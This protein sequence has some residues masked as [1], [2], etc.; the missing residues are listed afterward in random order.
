MGIISRAVR[1][2]ERRELTKISPALL[3]RLDGR[4]GMWWEGIGAVST[5][6]A[7]RHVAVWASINYIAELIA[8]LPVHT[9][10][11]QGPARQMVPSPPLV[12]NP[13]QNVS[14]IAWRRQ[15]LV[16]AL[17]HGNAVGIITRR[18]PDTFQAREIEIAHPNGVG[19]EVK[20]RRLVVSYL[21][22]PIPRDDLFHLTAYETPGSPVGLSPIRYIATTVYAG[23]AAQEFGA[24]WFAEGATPAALLINDA[25][26]DQATAQTAKERWAGDGTSGRTPRV[27]GNGWRYQPVQVPADES[28]FLATINANA[29]HIATFYGL[30]P[31]DIGFKSGDSMTYQ[32]VEQAQI[33][34]LVY[35]VHAWVRRIEESL[36]AQLVAP[37]EY[38]K[39]NTD[40]LIRVD[41]ATRYRAHDSAI[42]MGLATVNERRA[43]EDMP[44]V[45]GGDDR[46]WPPYRAF[47]TADE[48]GEG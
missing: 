25:T 6:R 44:P 31:E 36:T 29:A 37:D 26:I 19:Y 8:T 2:D 22:T 15:L 10:R 21:G 35:P 46:L 20:D 40:A 48:K 18:D 30:R 13:D 11:G 1:P 42:R 16:A 5:D 47:P 33:G 23:L 39:L 24:R 34:R 17:S 14:A 12:T 41:T 3:Q 43:L 38:V 45:E 28:Q 27:L 4:T 32:N 9:Y 7:L